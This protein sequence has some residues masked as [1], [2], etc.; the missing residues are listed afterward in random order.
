MLESANKTARMKQIKY[1]LTLVV[2]LLVS[3]NSNAQLTL[4]QDITP[5]QAA[6]QLVGTGVLID[7]VNVTAADSSWAYYFNENTE[8]D[9]PEGLL[10]TTGKARNAVVVDGINGTG[11]PELEN[12]TECVNC[13]EFD[14]DFPG[15]ELLNTVND[16]TTFD[17]TTFEFDVTVQGDSLLFD[18]TFASEEY[19]EWVGSQFNDVFGFFI[20][21]PGGFNDVNIALIPETNETV[22]IN[23]VNNIVNTEYY[24][25]NRNPLGQ[26]IQYDGFTLGLQAKVGGLTPCETYTLKLIIADG[27]DRLYDSAVFIEQ[28]SSNFSDIETSTEGGTPYMI[29]GCNDG[30][31]TFIPDEILPTDQEIL[32]SFSGSADIGV[33]YTANPSLGNNIPDQIQSIT[34]PANAGSV[35]VEINPVQDGVDE[36]DEFITLYTIN[37]VC[38]VDIQDSILFIIKDSLELDV[39]PL[40][41]TICA[42][43]TALLEG[44]SDTNGNF[45]FEWSPAET[46][47]TSTELITE[48]SPLVNTTYT[49]SST[50]ADCNAEVTTTVEV[51]IIELT[52]D[53]T[54][55]NCSGAAIGEIDLTITNAALPFNIS[56]TDSN[57][58][59]I[60]SDED[61]SGLEAGN[62]TVTVVDADGCSESLEVT[63]FE[64]NTL[65]ANLEL[66]NYNGSNITCNGEC[67]GTAAVN[68]TGGDAP[69]TIVWSE[70]VPDNSTL[71]E[72]LCPGS[73]TVTISD[74]SGCE[75]IVNFEITEP[76]PLEGEVV[77]VNEILCNG[78]STGEATVTAT[79]GTAPYFYSWSDDPSGTPV[80]GQGPTLISL[81][82][83][84]YFVSV[85]DANGCIA[86]NSVE[87]T[88]APPPP[89]IEINLT[90]FPFGNGFN[91]SCFDSSDA[92]ITGI[93]SGGTPGYTRV[94]TNGNGDEVGSGIILAG[95]PCDTYTLTV[96][97]S[98]GC[99]ESE[100]ITLDCPEE[101]SI[102][103]TVTPNPCNT[104]MAMDGE[105]DITP[106]GGTGSGYTFSWTDSGGADLGGSEDLTNLLSDTYTVTVTDDDGCSNSFDIT[107]TEELD[108]IITVTDIQ[109]VSCFNGCDGLIDIELSNIVGDYTVEWSTFEGVFS[110]QEDQTGL[111]ADTYF[112]VVTAEDGCQASEQFIITQPN[113]IIIELEDAVDPIC[114]GQNSGSIDMT[115][116]GGSG[117]LTLE[118]A[119]LGIFTGSNDEDISELT[120]G[121][122][123]LTV[124]DNVTGC[125]ETVEVTLEAPPIIEID[126]Q[127]SVYD[128]GFFTSCNGEDDGQLTAAAFGGNPDFTNLPFGYTYDWSNLPA[129]ND[130]SQP[131]QLNLPGGITYGLIV[132]DTAGCQAQLLIPTLEPEPL[133]A[134]E[135]ISNVS[136]FGLN[137]GFIVPNVTGGSGNYTSYEWTGDI[138]SNEIDADTLFN[139]SPGN[140]SLEVFDSNGCTFLEEFEITEPPILEVD[141]DDISVEDCFGDGTASLTVSA[142]GGTPDYTFSWIDDSMNSYTG[143]SLT[144]LVSGEYYLTITDENG[145]IVQDTIDINSE[146][147]F[148][149]D[150]EVF[151]TGTGDFNLA[152]LGDENASAEATVTGGVPDYTYEWTDVNDDVIG[153]EST[154]ADLGAGSYAITVTDLSGCELEENFIITEPDTEFTADA[155][156]VSPISCF[157]SC[158]GTVEINA[159]GGDPEYTYLWELDNEELEFGASSDELC[160][161][162]YEVLVV[163][164]NGCDTLITFNLTQPE[165]ILIDFNITEYEGGQNITCFGET[166]GQIDTDISGGTPAYELSWVGDIG[167]NTIDSDTL[168]NVGAGTY[169]LTVTDA[170]NCSVEAIITLE[171]P[172]SLFVDPIVTNIDCFDADNGSIDLNTQGGTPDFSYTWDHT[173]DNTQAV[174]EL[175]AEVY[176]ATVT[177]SNGCEVSAEIEITEPELLTVSATAENTSCGLADGSINTTV[178]G[179]VEP[180]S[181]DWDSDAADVEDPDNLSGGAYNLIL[182]DGNGCIINLPVAVSESNGISLGDNTV[183]D[184]LCFGDA[185]G[186]IELDIIEANGSVTETWFNADGENVNPC[187]DAEN[188]IYS[189]GDYSVDLVDENGCEASAN[190]TI[191]QPEELIVELNSPLLT[192]GYN[193]SVFQG[194][195]GVIET[196]ISGGTPDYTTSWTSATG[197]F[198]SESED[199]ADLTANTY[200]IDVTDANGCLTLDTIEVT[201]PLDLDIPTGFTPNSDGSND[202]YVV[203]GLDQY[204]E[205]TL[206]VFNRWGNIVYQNDNYDNEWAGQNNSNEE[207]ADG[208]YFVIVVA[209]RSNEQ[210]ELNSY[211]DLRR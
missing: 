118:W 169:N 2:G 76:L 197:S 77:S 150:L 21:G 75:I 57:G 120:E 79:G 109:N 42:G 133:E 112:L 122:Y 173:P 92:Q 89:P 108:I 78:T 39:T 5:E 31:I 52:T 51:K 153:M 184:I 178:S 138:G 205:V 43:E 183:T 147:V 132:T 90:A 200:F 6:Q 168:F 177:D 7:N 33:D 44:I 148:T 30:T 53:I 84:T 126:I 19:E 38:D 191:N 101:I 102:T 55:V 187:T 128:G 23:S 28:L 64:Q 82:D 185:N 211:V 69:Y 4:D 14:N 134:A 34:I 201:Q 91:T 104:P 163:D 174:E 97:D 59:E 208:T 151:T 110:D 1:I 85:T 140:Y 135:T 111:C 67:D 98:F 131:N 73:Y 87:V 27:T 190:F 210:R 3:I 22:A 182:T 26:N 130:P 96:T 106:A 83:G 86:E 129:G 81:I 156:V 70:P 179:G 172:D 94:W 16:R 61:V 188:G 62:Y 46:L 107:V 54:P 123:N 144:D 60:S 116:S 127:S 95:V 141:I 137:D 189:A 192:N 180:Y 48:A 207:L 194:S 65:Q 37:T 56:W 155:L 88:V 63:V 93:V 204:D 206:T 159:S 8:L 58:V 160:S 167:S 119:P 146:E 35:S 125:T 158:D 49:L 199:L 203:L 40:T 12:Q 154:L 18:F 145:C 202:T 157:E 66:S 170:T 121:S 198:T 13:E 181:F 100:S 162:D 175:G 10:L 165:E 171:G 139:L 149:L 152:C 36:G 193:I 50:L 29:E 72:N 164:A 25:D 114:Q 142:S 196:D 20:T 45:T 103:F 105:I 68:P 143:S 9:S 15:S 71:I 11:L 186:C 117:D 161:G 113:E 176:N 136:C 32:Y 47:S 209:T 80:I 166:D 24:Y 74:V 17:A 115:V 195:D 124:T 99:V 41:Q